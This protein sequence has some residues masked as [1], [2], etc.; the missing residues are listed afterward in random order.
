MG[1]LWAV[2]DMTSSRVNFLRAR[3]AKLG[4]CVRFCRSCHGCFSVADEASCVKQSVMLMQGGHAAPQPFCSRVFS[5]QAHLSP[6]PHTSFLF[7]LDCGP[8][9]LAYVTHISYAQTG[10]L[11]MSTRLLP[12]LML[13]H[14][15]LA[16]S[17]PQLLAD[18]N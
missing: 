15:S 2:T 10:A 6:W 11:E 3:E 16:A 14:V 18:H 1:E 12:Q 8:T 17:W 7:W 4:V 13:F 9:I 5:M